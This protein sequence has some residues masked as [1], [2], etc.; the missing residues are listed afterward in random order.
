MRI[1]SGFVCTAVK[2]AAWPV[3]LGLRPL[4]EEKRD[5]EQENHARK[6]SPALSSVANHYTEG[7]RETGWNEQDQ[8]DFYEVGKGCRVFEGMCRV[9]IKKAAAIGSQFLD[10]LL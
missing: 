5:Y 1:T 10:S 9:G 7:I 4:H 2:S 6:E 8:Q 3:T